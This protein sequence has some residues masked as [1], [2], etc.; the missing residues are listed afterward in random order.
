MKNEI[1]II[2]NPVVDLAIAVKP[3]N[4]K[5]LMES[6]EAK[7]EIAVAICSDLPVRSYE[8]EDLKSSV[9]TIVTRLLAD[10]GTR[11]EMDD[12]AYLIGRTLRMIIKQYSALT[13]KEIRLAFENGVSG[14]YGDMY[15]VNI[16][17]IAQ[18]LSGY[19]KARGKFISKQS[20]QADI[21]RIEREDKIWKERN[22]NKYLKK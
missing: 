15:G 5:I 6:V 8:M 19:S 16:K 3:H 22:F 9:S 20:L 11:M 7:G 21:K 18:F 2:R 4:T 14:E 13:V 10:A 1:A 12:S 17:T